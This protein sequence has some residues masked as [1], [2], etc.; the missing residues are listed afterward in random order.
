M[1]HELR[2]PLTS[3]RG[4]SELLVTGRA[5]PLSDQQQRMVTMIDLSA[6]RLH[7]IVEDLIVVASLDAG[8]FRLRLEPTR[9]AAVVARAADEV[10]TTARDAG[11]TIAPDIATDLVVAADP[12]HL[13]RALSNL[14]TGAVATCPA[15]G[16]VA[17]T[18]TGHH[19]ATTV[20]VVVAGGRPDPLLAR[21]LCAGPVDT[22][23]LDGA[24]LDGAG[25]GLTVARAVVEHHGGRLDVTTD[26][27]TGTRIAV[28]LPSAD[29][30][31]RAVTSD[32]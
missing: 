1:S 29:L 20:A 5:G 21:L 30:P 16:T 11:V 6:V 7:G 25:I 26:P 18:A 22:A 24:E 10:A 13:H 2:T 14:L 27:G 3:I 23:E 19:A 31:S 8:D 9:L 17:V 28:T 15:G 12:R 32:R 4:Y